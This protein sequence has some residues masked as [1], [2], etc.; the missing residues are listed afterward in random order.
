MLR[1]LIVKKPLSNLEIMKSLSN[2][3]SLDSKKFPYNMWES[4]GYI[5]SHKDPSLSTDYLTVDVKLLILFSGVLGKSDVPP[6][7]AH[8][9]IYKYSVCICAFNSFYV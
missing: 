9:L 7:F 2:K 6:P 8:T 4:H 5:F 3:K 1:K